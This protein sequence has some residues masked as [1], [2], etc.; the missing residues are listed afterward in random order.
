MNTLKNQQIN[1]G[2][3]VDFSRIR[4]YQNPSGKLTARSTG[5]EDWEA[6]INQS[7][8]YKHSNPSG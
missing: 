1:P 5:A 3:R 7:K 6:F 2:N 8:I 4:K